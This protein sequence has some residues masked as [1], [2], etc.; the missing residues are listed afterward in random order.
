MK[1]RI[2]SSLS[3]SFSVHMLKKARTANSAH[4][5]SVCTMAAVNQE[6]TTLCKAGD[7]ITYKPVLQ[8]KGHVI[9]DSVHSITVFTRDFYISITVAIRSVYVAISG[10]FIQNVVVAP[11][12]LASRLNYIPIQTRKAEREKTFYLTLTIFIKIKRTC[13]VTT[14][15]IFA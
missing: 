9:V 6:A 4:S 1:Y 13:D 3:N 12:C 2:V 5:S 8:D 7:Y 15:R 14:A 11:S 10:K